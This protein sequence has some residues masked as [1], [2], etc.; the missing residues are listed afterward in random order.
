MSKKTE[1]T[2]NDAAWKLLFEKFQIIENVK[3]MDMLKSQ[4]TIS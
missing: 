1:V 4:Q 2:K 3:K